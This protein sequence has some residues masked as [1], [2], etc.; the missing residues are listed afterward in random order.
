[1]SNFTGGASIYRRPW[2]TID[3]GL[4]GSSLASTQRDP[5]PITSLA[6]AMKTHAQLPGPERLHE[7][8]GS[9]NRVGVE[10]CYSGAWS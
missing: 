6:Q 3:H 7:R 2:V 4:P 9:R 1:M 10:L 8:P 5:A